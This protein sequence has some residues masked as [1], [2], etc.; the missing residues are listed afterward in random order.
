MGYGDQWGDEECLGDGESA[1]EC[2][3]EFRGRGEGLVG[4]KVVE[5]DAPRLFSGFC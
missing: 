2:V 4:Q 3:L 5:E 1:D